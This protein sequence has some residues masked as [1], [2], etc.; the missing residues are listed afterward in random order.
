MSG[1]SHI[2]TTDDVFLGGALRLQQP[3][4]GYRAGLDAVL[5]AA[6]CPVTAGS[7]ARCLDCGAGVGTV[8][9]AL[10]R[11]VADAR[12]TLIERDP[13]L[14]D[15][16]KRN[17]AANGLT[18]RCRVIS[19]DLM[20]PLS[21]IAA[22]V[23]EAGTFDHVLANPPYYAHGDGTRARDRLKDGSHAM[24]AGSLEDWARFAAAMTRDGGSLTLIHRPDALPEILPA[25]QRRF[26][27]V[28]ILPLHP[29]AGAPASRMIIQGLKASRAALQI[30]AGH[31]LHAED[32]H[33]FT[34]EFDA[35]LRHGA[36]LELTP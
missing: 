4:S 7:A 2:A 31:V 1:A 34:P 11:R 25:L 6:A 18:D 36:A 9:L 16:A 19:D 10:A 29:R 32:A 15:L 12:V 14:A 22:L 13:A 17:A 35:I 23:G 24:Q 33:S 26:G 28:L 20:R 3:A 27:R 5:L 21:Q 8:G 30:L